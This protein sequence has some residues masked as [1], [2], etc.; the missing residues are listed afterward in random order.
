[1]AVDVA[2][3]ALELSTTGLARGEREAASLSAKIVGHFDRIEQRAKQVNAALGKAFTFG[4]GSG[5]GSSA[6]SGLSNSID[7]AAQSQKKYADEVLRAAQSQ[8]RLLQAQGNQAGAI[9]LLADATKNHEGSVRQLVSAQTQL[10]RLQGTNGFLRFASTVREAGES[11]QQTGYFLTGLSAGLISLGAAAVKSAFDVDKNVNTLKALLGSADAAESR[12]QALRKL[13]QATPG[14]TTGLASQLDVQL[15]VANATEKA[16]NK[17]LPAIGKLNAVSTL[18][19]TQKFVQNLVQ[20]VTQNFERIDLKELIGQSPLAGELIKQ[21]FNVDSAIDGAAIRES[22][23]KLGLTTV[24]AFFTAFGEAAAKN[25]KLANITESLET[26]FAKIIDRVTIA[27]RPLGEAIIGTLGPI[28]E[29]AAV[30]IEGLSNAFNSLPSGVKS[31]VVVFGALAVVIGPAVAGIG[32]FIQAAGALGNLASVAKSL[33]AVSLALQGTAVASEAAGV[34]AATAGA[35]TAAAFAPVLPIA[36]AVAAVVGVIALAWANYETATEKA[37]KITI[38]QIQAT[39]KSRDEL[40]G[41]SNSLNQS[42]NE[43]GKLAD[44]ISKMPPASQAFANALQDEGDKLAFVT[45]ELVRQRGAREAVLSSQTATI[46]A[47]LVEQQKELDLL[48]ARKTALEEEAKAAFAAGAAGQQLLVTE[49]SQGRRI[50]STLQAQ[51]RLGVAIQQTTEAEQKATKSRDES[52]AKLELIQKATG[53]TSQKLVEYQQKA[54]AS[55]EETSRLS[56]GISEYEAQ[57][58][59]AAGATSDTA[60]AMNDLGAAARQAGRDVANAFLQFDLQGIQKGIQSKTQELAQRIVKEGV[61]AKKAFADAQNQV[62]GTAPAEGDNFPS[63]LTF[64]EANRRAQALKKAQEEVDKL[65]NPST[66]S[67]SVSRRSESDARQLRAAEEELAKAI[68]KARLD[69]EENTIKKLIDLDKD[70]FD[71]RLI[72]AE[73]YYERLIQGELKLQDIEKQRVQAELAASQKRLTGAKAGS[74]EAIREKAQQIELESRLTIIETERA[75][76]VRKLNDELLKLKITEKERNDELLKAGA[77]V[78]FNAVKKFNDNF[79]AQQDADRSRPETDLRIR[80]AGL[81]GLANTG[82]IRESQLQDA[83]ILV[84]RNARQSLIDLAEARKAE[85]LA[86]EDL[87]RFDQAA[88]YD[89]EIASLRTLGTELTRAEQLQRRFAEQGVIDYSRLNEGVEDLLASQKGLTEIFSD[90]RAN[91]VKDQFDLIDRGVDSLTKRL[92]ILGDAIG[93]LL[94]DLAKLAVSKIFQKLFGI[95]GGSGFGQQPAFGGFAGGGGGQSLGGSIAGSL[96]G[97]SGGGGGFGQFATGGFAGGNPAQAALGGQGGGLQSILGGGGGGGLLSKIPVIGKF[98]GGGGSGGGVNNLPIFTQGEGGG[99]LSQSGGAA[100]GLGSSFASLG[101]GGLLAGGGL[102]GSLA[103]GNSQFGRLL[104]GVGGTLLGGALGASGLLGGGIAGAL[105][106]LFSNP[107]TAIIGGALIGGALLAR[108]FADREF[109]KFRKITKNQ[110]QIEVDKKAA[111]RGLYQSEKELGEQMFGKGKFGKKI[112]D[113]IKSSKG[114]QLLAQYA[115]ATGQENNPLVRKYRDIKELTDVDDPR[116]QFVKRAYGGSVNAGQPYIVGDAGRP[117]VFV[118]R[119][120]GQIVPSLSDF[121]RLAAPQR[122]AAD[123]G[124]GWTHEARMMLQMILTQNVRLTDALNRFE[125]MPP[126]YVVTTGAAR[127]PDVIAE[128]NL[129][130]MRRNSP[131]G[132]AQKDEIYRGR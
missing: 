1:M 64:G 70:G 122:E 124:G 33:Q 66:R 97:G 73:S 30:L 3:L 38:D 37:A 74:P 132:L 71:K 115:E 79:F 7:K 44:T 12:F 60:G 127:V 24:D 20:L 75:G 96:L 22:A 125:S 129:T 67:R 16:I 19:D 34:A 43:H 98:F 45:D 81:Q 105:P 72:S 90:F 82:L 116:N 109:N 117:E 114:E 50:E 84:R 107:V 9:R 76:T 113:T 69:I 14:L 49:S 87:N 89:E 77:S 86:T 92:G 110:Y 2:T 23:Q 32:A 68:A 121:A 46:T 83:L 52:A 39:I 61:S 99:V 58:R 4:G 11:I 111:G 102:L 15:R 25:S 59:K 106:A 123:V 29:R 112:V 10:A 65:V 51:A 130:S 88:R 56:R 131:A 27:L 48:R 5:G 62:I 55:A 40:T 80:E 17:V 26:R 47:G 119:R 101:A 18:G 57:Q 120:D 103:G 31:A 8:A 95:G 104:G 42:T 21:I 94:K 126:E 28:V 85:V 63:V 93:S 41:L 128:A 36:L 35:T 100:T 118:P 53:Q 78:G 13:S 91:L 54:G 6:F 108:F